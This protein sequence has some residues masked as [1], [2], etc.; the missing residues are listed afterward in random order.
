MHPIL[1][2]CLCIGPLCG[3][4]ITIHKY[5]ETGNNQIIAHRD[6]VVFQGLVNFSDDPEVKYA[7]FQVLKQNDDHYNYVCHF[8]LQTDCTGEINTYDS[9]CT[10]KVLTDNVIQFNV[11]ISAIASLNGAILRGVVIR[12]YDN[13]QFVSEEQPFPAI[14]EESLIMKIILTFS[15]A[16]VVGFYY[17]ARWF[18][19]KARSLRSVTIFRRFLNPC[20]ASMSEEDNRAPSGVDFRTDETGGETQTESSTSGDEA[21]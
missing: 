10:C 4:K 18:K 6:A 5:D 3:L 20:V 21:S 2:L 9:E 19:T 15:V 16:L 17:Q 11:T 12:S 7:Y 8:R 14:Y 1:I 13:R